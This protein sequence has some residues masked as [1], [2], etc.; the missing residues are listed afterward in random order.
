MCLGKGISS[1]LPI[2]ALI[3]RADLM[4]QF[5]PGSMTSTHTGNPICVAAALASID[6]IVREKLTENARRVGQ[7]MQ[8]ELDGIT[9]RFADVVGA[10]Q[11][12]GLVAGLHM[13]KPGSKE[14]DA[15][16]AFAVVARCVEKGLLFFSPVGFGGATV[17]IAPPLVISEAA[18]R[19]GVGVIEEALGEVL[20]ERRGPARRLAGARRVPA[21]KAGAGPHRASGRPR[22]TGGHPAGTR[23]VRV[24]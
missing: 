2:S 18:V 16:L 12:K 8:D 17:K 1:S 9:E 6:T 13:V 11:G 21:R 10:R 23:R 3:G 4:D 24:S 14:P 15:D 20:A 19:E 22:R 5:P 7:V